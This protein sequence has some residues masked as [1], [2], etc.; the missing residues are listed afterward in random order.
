MVVEIPDLN[1]SDGVFEAFQDVE[2]MV[3]ADQ[4]TFDFRKVF[5]ARPFCTLLLAAFIKRVAHNRS[6]LGKRTQVSNYQIPN[7]SALGYL[8]YIGFFRFIGIDIGS[9]VGFQGNDSFVPISYITRNDFGHSITD[10]DPVGEYVQAK[11]I[12]LAKLVTQ[13]TQSVYYQAIAYCFREILRNV[14]EHSRAER[15]ILCA[16]K[17]RGQNGYEIELA[18]IDRGVGIA[19]TLKENTEIEFKENADALRLSIQ[20]GVSRVMLSPDVNDNDNPWQN[21]GFGLYVL[22]EIGKRTGEFFLISGDSGLY[23][24]SNDVQDIG[25]AFDGTAMKLVI[26]RPTGISLDDLI[27]RIIED[28][29]AISGST[30]SVRKASG[31]TR[32]IPR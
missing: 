21:S 12:E 22:S 23:C 5:F 20:P 17:Y 32:I 16:Q 2:P 10:K 13:Q 14:F 11:A 29:E 15:C 9:L 28:G 6:K 7:R 25:K 24:C 4:L 30:G 27:E 31:S 3:E 26:N 1:N 19:T 8:S 18:V